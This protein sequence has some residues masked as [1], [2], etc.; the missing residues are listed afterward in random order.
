VANPAIVEDRI[1]LAVIAAL[2]KL[3]LQRVIRDRWVR[4]GYI[5][6]MNE[7]CDGGASSDANEGELRA[8]AARFVDLWQRQLKIMAEDPAL[9]E[10]MAAYRKFG[11]P[12]FGTGG[13]TD[14]SGTP[15]DSSGKTATSGTAPGAEAA[16]A[17]SRQRG[18]ELDEL[19]RR[20]AACEE[21]LAQ[22]EKGT[23]GGS[24]SAGKR[25]RKPKT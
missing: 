11:A 1:S 14:E 17:S 22:L 13:G 16:D 9:S 21:R 24:A 12:G 10:M 25:A 4:L 6:T 23:V 2:R 3:M 15:N 7:G 19:A 20:V 18:I 5:T 8:L